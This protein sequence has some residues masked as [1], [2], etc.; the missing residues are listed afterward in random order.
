MEDSPKQIE[1]DQIGV[2]QK[3]VKVLKNLK[4]AERRA[5]K[6]LSHLIEG[7]Q[8]VEKNFESYKQIIFD[9]SRN[10][11]QMLNQKSDI[12]DNQFLN[13]IKEHLKR[14]E[15]TISAQKDMINALKDMEHSYGEYLSNLEKLENAWED[16][17]KTGGNWVN[18]ANDLQREKGG[19]AIG[20]KLDK[21]E[22]GLQKSK[23]KL[24]KAYVKR[25]NAHQL[26]STAY[27]HVNQALQKFK[28]TIKNIRW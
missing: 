12:I 1:M 19:Y 16:L 4:K 27:D 21:L 26:V 17:V 7:F 20:S 24:K 2:E 25:M 10:Y 22:K 9:S 5:L 11:I 18:Y 14:L 8:D 6:D 15:L 23:E 28:A 3:S 13:T